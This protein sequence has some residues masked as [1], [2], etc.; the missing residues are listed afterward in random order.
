MGVR[1]S[2]KRDTVR[3]Y[4]MTHLKMAVHNNSNIN[5]CRIITT[6]LIVL[7]EWDN[8]KCSVVSTEGK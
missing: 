8:R 6:Y 1:I 3:V 5:N 2:A 4:C 7:G